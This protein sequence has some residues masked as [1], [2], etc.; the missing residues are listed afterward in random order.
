LKQLDHVQPGNPNDLPFPVESAWLGE[1]GVL[2]GAEQGG[3]QRTVPLRHG[4]AR[5]PPL[6][7]TEQRI[8]GRK[9]LR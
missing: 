8:I 5:L 4:L 1:N 7:L 3:N 2:K 6:P 9:F